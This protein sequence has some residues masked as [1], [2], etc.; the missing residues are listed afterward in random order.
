M[1]FRSAEYIRKFGYSLT[2]DVANDTSAEDIVWPAGGEC[3]QVGLQ[4]WGNDFALNIKVRALACKDAEGNLIIAFDGLGNKVD[5]TQLN[6]IID[7]LSQ[8][9]VPSTPVEDT[10]EDT[11]APETS[12]ADN[13]N[14]VTTSTEAAAT[15][16]EAAASNSSST[17]VGLIIGIIAAVVVVIIVIVIIVL[18]KKK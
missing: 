10:T 15:T 11:A 3:Y 18:K 8:P 7:D 5:E 4:E 2:Y 16:T 6:A 17:N 12:A 9:Y 14:D 13:N 1:L